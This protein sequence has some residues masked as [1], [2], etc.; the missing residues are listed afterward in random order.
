MYSKIKELEL[1]A[2]E[3]E[4][5]E[6]RR[7][8]L[9]GEVNE[10]VED[11]YGRLSQGKAYNPAYGLAGEILNAEINEE[12]ASMGPVLDEVREKVD[13]TGI[14]TAS[15]GHLG[16]IPGGGLYTSALGDYLA[17]VANRYAGVHYSSPGAVNL[18]RR[19]IRW[20]AD[21]VGYPGEAGG[22]LASGGSIANLTAIITAR[23]ATGLKSADFSES[24]VYLTDQTHHCI[25]RALRIA[26]MGECIQRKIEIDGRFRM[27][28]AELEQAIQQ[29]RQAGKKPWLV[30]G[31]AGTTDT[32]AVD[33]LRKQGEVARQNG[34]WFH[35]D[36]AYGGFFLLA[37]ETAPLFD[38]IELSDSVVLDPHK[39]MF[40]PYGIGAVILKDEKLMAQA[41]TYEASY[42]QDVLDQQTVLSPADTSPELS[43]HF[44]GLR[45]WLPLMIHGVSAF[46]AALREKV[47]LTRY[48]HQKLA[49]MPGFEVGPEPDLSVVLFRLN[50]EGS[51]PDASTKRLHQLMLDDGRIY[52][53]STRV[54]GQYMLRLAVL[55]VRTH[56][57]TVDLTLQLL[58]R[59]SRQAITS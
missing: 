51:D 24:V 5:D 3:L 30:I 22:Y 57:S 17:A 46:R 32:G 19:L 10:Y 43:K 55:S 45:M 38:G 11:F 12:P 21:L 37:E 16:Y 27:K 20:M 7:K 42:M 59:Y 40:L 41:Y 52:I 28:P 54:A 1:Q 14:N 50:P 9:S 13:S 33:P 48:A 31:S 18:E 15:G 36:A 39:G 23:E 29:D 35:V 26:G 34:L 8:Q 56:I 47:W 6:N 25:D 4:P 53:S 49:E 44:R 2:L 58:Q